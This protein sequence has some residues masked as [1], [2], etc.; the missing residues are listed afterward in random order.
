MEIMNKQIYDKNRREFCLTQTGDNSSEDIFSN[1]S[2]QII[3]GNVVFRTVIFCQ[4]K[5]SGMMGIY[6]FKVSKKA[7]TYIVSQYDLRIWEGRA[8]HELPLV[9]VLGTQRGAHKGGGKIRAVPSGGQGGVLNSLE[10]LF[11]SLLF[12]T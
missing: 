9:H 6:F 4:N 10:S 11:S 5:I 2:E 7:G 3:Q 1:C 12:I 8:H